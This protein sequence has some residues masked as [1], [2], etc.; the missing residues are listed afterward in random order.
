VDLGANLEPFGLAGALEVVDLPAV[1]VTD[2]VDDLVGAG[3]AGT[4]PVGGD[5]LPVVLAQ[6]QGRPFAVAVT[7]ADKLGLDGQGDAA[8][9]AASNPVSDDGVL[10]GAAEV[11]LGEVQQQARWLVIDEIPHDATPDGSPSVDSPSDRP[12]PPAP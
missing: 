8:G 7:V 5:D 9:G 11:L 12:G 6:V 1:F 2:P 10:A 4:G 3:Q